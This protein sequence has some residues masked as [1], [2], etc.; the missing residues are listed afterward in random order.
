LLRVVRARALEEQVLDEMRDA[1]T[2]VALVTGAGADPEAERDRA[3]ARNLLGDH[4]LARVEFG[5]HVFLHEA[6]LTG[7]IRTEVFETCSQRLHY[8]QVAVHCRAVPGHRTGSPGRG[9]GS[10]GNSDEIVG[11]KRYFGRLRPRPLRRSS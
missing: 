1:G 4:P 7:P 8:P 5:K 2:V 9:S 3:D 6:I 11:T 10:L